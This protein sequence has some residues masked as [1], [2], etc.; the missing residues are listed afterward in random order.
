MSETIETTHYIETTQTI[1][2][3]IIFTMLE[4]LHVSGNV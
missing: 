3:P 1:K 2:L 4:Q